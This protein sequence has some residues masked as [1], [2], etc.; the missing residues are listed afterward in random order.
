L[1]REAPFEKQ[2]RKVWFEE[3]AEKTV[4][5]TDAMG[6]IGFPAAAGEGGS[7]MKA[8]RNIAC[9]RIHLLTGNLNS[10]LKLARMIPS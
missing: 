6:V 3:L 10:T 5:V 8:N 4:G 1:P 2:A 9:R 7:A